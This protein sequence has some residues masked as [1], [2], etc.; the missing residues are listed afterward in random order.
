MSNLDHLLK[1]AQEEIRLKRH[2]WKQ[3]SSIVATLREKGWSYRRIFD[4]LK[5]RGEPLEEKD[6]GRFRVAI[7]TRANRQRKGAAQ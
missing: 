4:W 5:D 2:N 7:S 1:E 6:F 3:Y